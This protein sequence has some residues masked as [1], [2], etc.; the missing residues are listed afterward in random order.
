MNV[1]FMALCLL[2][3]LL[4]RDHGLQR[5][6]EVQIVARRVEAEEKIQSRENQ[7]ETQGA[8]EKSLPGSRVS[9]DAAQTAQC[10]S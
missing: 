10:R 3:C 1:P 9:D 4:I 5:P 7:E 6:D 8:S 2:G